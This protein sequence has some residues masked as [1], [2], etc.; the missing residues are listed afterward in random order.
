MTVFEMILVG[1]IKALW[2]EVPLAIG[3]LLAYIGEKR[4][5]L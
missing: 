4:E 3:I 5:W 2:I 1:A